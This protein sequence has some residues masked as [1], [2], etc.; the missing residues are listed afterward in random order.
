MDFRHLHV[1]DI[2]AVVRYSPTSP[3][4][5]T[6]NRKDH[7]IGIQLHGTGFHDFG[8]QNFVISRNDIYFL[9]QKDDYRD[10]IGAFI[11]EYVYNLGCSAQVGTKYIVKSL[12]EKVRARNGEK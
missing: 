10:K 9:N 8:Y 3:R 6:Q 11:E 4:W 1:H 7:I 12:Q 2:L 5:T